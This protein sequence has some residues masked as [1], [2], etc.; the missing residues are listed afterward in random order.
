MS[1]GAAAGEAACSMAVQYVRIV[2]A[3]NGTSAPH[4]AGIGSEEPAITSAAGTC[5]SALPLPGHDDCAKR[6]DGGGGGGGGVSSA[7]YEENRLEAPPLVLD[8]FCGHGTTLALANAWGMDAYGL[9]LNRMRCQTSLT[10]E[11]KGEEEVFDHQGV[12][13]GPIRYWGGPL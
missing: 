13:V 11:C 12:R 2:A 5:A 1:Y 3:E 9:D 8:P 10:R 7:L 4:A 6:Q